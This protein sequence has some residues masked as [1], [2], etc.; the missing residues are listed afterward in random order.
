MAKKHN[1]FS[2]FRRNQKAWMA[3]LTLFT[4]FSFIALGS[5][6]QCVGSRNQGGGV[7]Y[8]GEVAKS[9]EF[10]TLD[11]NEYLALRLDMSRF[12]AFLE[13]LLTA[14]QSATNPS[15]PSPKLF[16]LFFEVNAAES[17]PR[18]LV[19]RWLITKFAERDK[20]LADDAAAIAYLDSLTKIGAD[21]KPVQFNQDE[22]KA[23]MGRAGLGEKG[24]FDLVKGQVAY[25]RFIRKFD[26]GAQTGPSYLSTF[27]RN[28]M[29]M[30]F[31]GYYGFQTGPAQLYGQGEMRFTPAQKLRAYEA[32]HRAAKAKVAVF[33][34][35]NYIDQVADPSD[36]VARAFYERHKDIVDTGS[37][38]EPGFT[39]PLML[40]M[41]IVRASVAKVAETIGDDEVK[42]FYDEHKEEFRI[43]K[44]AVDDAVDADLP[45]ETISLDGSDSLNAIPDAALDAIGTEE[46]APA[47]ATPAEQPTETAPAEAAPEQ[48]A[49]EAAPAE[50]GAS[51]YLKS[52]ASSAYAQEAQEEPAPAEEAPAEQP[53]EEAAPAEEAPAEQP[54]EEAAPAEDEPVLDPVPAEEAEPEFYEFDAVKENIR[55]HL[56]AVRVEEALEKLQEGLNGDY[57]K[58]LVDDSGKTEP[59]FDMAKFAAE[60]GFE[61][62]MTTQGDEEGDATPILISHQGAEIKKLLPSYELSSIYGDS[63][64]QV[65]AP[66]R[67]PRDPYKLSSVSGL[68]SPYTPVPGEFYFYRVLER[69]A[70]RQLKYERDKNQAL[71][72]E[73]GE[74]PEQAAERE[75]KEFD[76]T[77]EKVVK[78]YKLM[79][80]S[81]LAKAAADEFA[82]KA[83]ADGADFDALAKEANAAVVETEKFTWFVP[84]LYGAGPQLNEVKE[85]K[86]EAAEGETEATTEV[87]NTEILEPDWSFYETVFGLEQGG[88]GTCANAPEDRAFAIKV[89]E[90]DPEDAISAEEVVADSDA[91]AVMGTF[92]IV[93]QNKYRESFMETLRKRAG[94]EWVWIPRAE[95]L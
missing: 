73:D 12:K 20:L 6:L 18:A 31:P 89:V 87:S 41:E 26:G 13:T 93:E 76:A 61:Y 65:L 54:A 7:H 21:G 48:P 23:A 27:M 56:A 78:A 95:E 47:D 59:E 10:G 82:E 72:V 94:F 84:G 44:K 2:I 8:I 51:N 34:A 3:G 68:A 74:T 1:P 90:K 81:K 28:L 45:Q 79:E 9:S 62:H 39:Q 40:A 50:E 64:P 66:R 19:D 52:D 85:A 70:Q 36:E 83:K 69:D 15:M 14:S 60:N 71:K 38:K 67:V 37:A 35:E 22:L 80:A 92:Y 4:M 16:N 46:A 42:A 75:Q 29:A 49:E 43:P 91:D 77:K 30:R 33:K 55:K 25:E 11:Y 88:I 86:A 17:D 5:M 53:A 24:L 57:Q 63:V 58:A 32:L